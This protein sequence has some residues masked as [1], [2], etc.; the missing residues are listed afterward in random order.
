MAVQ[1]AEL[2]VKP[3]RDQHRTRGFTSIRR[4]Q[5]G[6]FCLTHALGIDPRRDP[7]VA[8]AVFNAFTGFAGA[9]FLVMWVP[10]S[11]GCTKDEYEVRTFDIRNDQAV[12]EDKVAFSIVVP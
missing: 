11:F 3:T 4:V 12:L 5:T 7:A 8:S 10:S 9:Q 1:R 6:T 2:P